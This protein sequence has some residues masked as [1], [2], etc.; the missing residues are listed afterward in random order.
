[1][2]IMDMCDNWLKQVSTKYQNYV[3]YIICY[4]DF[5]DKS[6]GC[7]RPLHRNSIWAPDYTPDCNSEKNVVK[8]KVID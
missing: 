5:G 7:T 4:M 6:T 1:M 3:C 8:R 2:V